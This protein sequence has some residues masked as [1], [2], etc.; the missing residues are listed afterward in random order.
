MVVVVFAAIG[1]G[2]DLAYAYV[3]SQA[4][5][6]QAQLT[7]ELQ[8]GQAQLEVGK[9]NLT[10]A[11]T[12]H[13]AYWAMRS[14][15]HFGAAKLFFEEA[16]RLADNSALLRDLEH[17]P[18]FGNI[19][20]SRHTAVGGIAAMGAGVSDAGL[21][22]AALDGELISPPESG[23]AG[24]TLL[25][26]LDQ[27]HTGLIKVRA[28]FTRA[29]K[30]ASQVDISVVPAGQQ[31]T[32]LKARDT[33]ASALAGLD[34][35]ERLV[36]IL[37]DVLGGNG[38]RNY[39]VEQVNPAELR[40]GGGFI[41]TYSVIRADQGSLS[42]IRSGDSY[43]LSDPRPLPGQPGFI[44][45][46]D[47]VRDIIPWVSWS[48]VDT[49][50]FPDFPSNARAAEQ[51]A[52]PR[53]GMNIDAVISIDYYAVAKMLEL[54]GPL[55]VPGFGRT[56]D[57]SNFIPQVMQLEFANSPAHK[58][59]LSAIA[60]PLMGRVSA[61]PAGQWPTLISDLNALAGQRHIQAYFNNGLVQA[62][63]DRVGW[64]GTF[65]PTENADYMMAVESNI[66]GGKV[67]YFLSRH[68]TVTLTRTGNVLHHRVTVDLINNQPYRSDW[69]V[70]Y[71]AYGSLYAGET[72]SAP[73]DNLR[74]AKYGKPSPPS[75]AS[76][77]QGW[78][79]DVQCCGGHGQAVFQYDTPWPAHANGNDEIYWQKQPGTVNDTIDVV[80]NDGLGQTYR[81]SGDLGADRVISLTTTGVKLAAGHPAQATLPSL[82]LG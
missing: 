49:N 47:P 81:T 40:P 78:L 11:N 61:L 21:D 60:G 25:T 13:D 39:L 2:I 37:K 38:V 34:E 31:A 75:G 4:G 12:T 42:V 9:A 36:P 28:D 15:A 66:G 45:Q 63:I 70:D 57:A 74:P 71:L 73:S 27:A 10:Q 58:A 82:S 68:Y 79:P 77:L 17:L 80:W 54:T 50:I 69:I 65:N 1:G 33:I 62:E 16:G 46:P 52:Q 59:I 53:L 29:Q 44:P 43:V 20:S 32:F 26:V 5:Q 18:S 22:L 35:F 51:F 14:A 72:V 48:F 7:T 6:L 8:A 55:P 64:S 41:G 56:V 3:K 76:L 24:R 30:A 23:S 67:N 19:A